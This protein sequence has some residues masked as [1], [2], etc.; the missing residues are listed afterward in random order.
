M[1]SNEMDQRILA[2]AE[3]YFGGGSDQTTKYEDH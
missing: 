2:G 3:F 1:I